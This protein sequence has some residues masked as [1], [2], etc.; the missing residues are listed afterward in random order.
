M[1]GTEGSWGNPVDMQIAPDGN[2]AYLG[3][4]SAELNEIVANGANNPPVAA[5]SADNTSTTGSSLTVQFSS[6]GSHDPDGDPIDFSWDFGDG[7]SPSTEAGPSHTYTTGVYQAKLTVTD[8]GGATGSATIQINVGIEAP[9]V[10]ITNPDPNVKF[11]IGDT[12]AVKVK[13]ND[14]Q[15]GNL[16]GDH[17]STTIQYWT[18]GHM[19][20][21]VD[22][23]GLSGSFVAADNGFVN[24]FYRIITTATNSFGI[25]GIAT[26]DVLPL[27]APVTVTSTPFGLSVTVDGLPHVTPYTFTT[28]VGS[29]REVVAPKTVVSGGKSYAFTSWRVGSGTATTNTFKSYIVPATAVTVHGTYTLPSPPPSPPV[30]GYWIVDA[31][32]GVNRVRTPRLRRAALEARVPDRRDGRDAR[33]PRLL[34]RRSRRRDLRVR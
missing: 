11:K 25:S 9:V 13:A 32:G 16:G 34:A 30:S 7:S 17:V 4:G 26:R 1:F 31:A 3:L 23:N 22:F 14:P 19:F 29:E 15:D 28:I 33:R 27:T 8:D 6:A 20:P 24:V 18:G 21:V 2:V 5:V 12:I 10:H